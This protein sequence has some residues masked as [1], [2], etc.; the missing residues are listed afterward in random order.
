M[1]ITDELRDKAQ[2]AASSAK[3]FF[4]EYVASSASLAG[5]NA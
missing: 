2:Q 3:N 5:R 4:E 1:A